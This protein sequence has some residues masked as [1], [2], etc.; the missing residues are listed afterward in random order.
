MLV[1][2]VIIVFKLS[3][4]NKLI[5]LFCFDLKVCQSNITVLSF[6]SI[7]P[8]QYHLPFKRKHAAKN[9]KRTWFDG[10]IER[11][12]KLPYISLDCLSATVKHSRITFLL[13]YLTL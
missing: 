6:I 11:L 3:S 7:N 5:N 4:L 9:M 2:L 12:V 1:I 8:F 10:T 13:T